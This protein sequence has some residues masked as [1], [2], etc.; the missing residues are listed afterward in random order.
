[1]DTTG[2]Q[3]NI[4]F[5]HAD[6]KTEMKSLTHV[7]PGLFHERATRKQ[8][9]K[10]FMTRNAFEKHFIPSKVNIKRFK[11]N[12][13]VPP[14]VPA[15]ALKLDKIT[16]TGP[17]VHVAGRY[18]KFSRNLCQS[19]WILEGKKVMEDSVQ[20][21]IAA[22][23]APVFGIKPTQVVFM[24]S[25]REDVDVRCLGKGRPFVIE[26]P[27]AKKLTLL[28][29]EIAHIKETVNESKRVTIRDLQIVNRDEL[30]HIKTGEEN[31]K[32]FYRALCVTEKAITGD[33]MK[34]LQ[35]PNGFEIKQITPIR[36]LHRRTLLE[37]PR[38]VYSLKGYA[39]KGIT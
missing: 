36:V 31:K 22:Q 10:E 25:G 16:L 38:M 20:E 1:M 7:N 17:T 18:C 8:Y 11:S 37:R 33:L 9:N 19:P 15:T 6:D 39:V 26:I 29:D 30:F 34:K 21:I 5:S 24:A 4:F 32:K 35:I 3:I 28:E 2:L 27:D 23:I 13:T 12:I 14:T